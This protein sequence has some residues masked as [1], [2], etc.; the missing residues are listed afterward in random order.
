MRLTW[1]LVVATLS[2]AVASRAE[3]P[4]LPVIAPGLLCRAAIDATERGRSIPAHLLAAIGRVESG[5][6]DPATGAWHP[7]PWTVNAEGQGYFYESKA[8]AVAA[9]RSMQ[10]QGMR[11]I[12]VGCL[13]VNLMHHPNAFASLEMAFEPQVN[14]AYAAR[15]L[16]ALFARSGDWTKAA[17]LYHSATPD[18]GADYQREVLAAWP[19][20]QRLA[21]P[22]GASA[23]A[24]AWGATMTAA[25]PGFTRV[26]RMQPPRRSLDAYRGAPNGLAY[27]G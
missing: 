4:P 19:E 18:V 14:A 23:L 13:Q 7:W 2:L 17:A 24:R 1:V 11:S 21:S 3:R 16:E 26:L 27:G 5:R 9:V 15:F 6:R 20:E 12:D 25:P 10:A 22:V 8:A